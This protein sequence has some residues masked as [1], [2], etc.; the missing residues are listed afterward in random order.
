MVKGSI[1]QLGFNASKKN[2]SFEA[3]MP[4]IIL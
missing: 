4:I 3:Q 1:A 2:L